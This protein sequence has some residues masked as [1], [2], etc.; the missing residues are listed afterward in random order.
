MAGV[1]VG[2][3]GGTN[4]RF[5][6]ADWA[7][8]RLVLSR[9]EL[10]AGEAFATFEDAVGH[11]LDATGLKPAGACIAVAGPVRDGAAHLTNR[12]WR[13]SEAVLRDRFGIAAPLVINDFLAMA[14]SVPEM[15]PESFE[16]VYD[17]EAVA[18]APLIVAG[19]GTGFGVSTL[20]PSPKG[21]TVL[22]GEGGHIAYA[23]RTALERELAAVLARDHGYVSNELVAS[24]SGLDEVHA[25]LSEIRGVPC[26]K[27]TAAEMQAKAD[28][29]DGFFAEL[30]Q[31]RALA[32]MGAVGD[33]A[34]AN[35]ALGGVVLAGGVSE[36]L[37]AY[38]RLPAMRERFV[39]RGPMSDYLARC[40]VRL[41][42]NPEAPLIGAA[43]H[44][45]QVHGV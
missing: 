42:R 14:R 24:G 13:V 43:A 37:A 11:Y 21:W 29:G 33:L 40:P 25:A 41:L 28:A 9:V 27:M 45:A 38:F 23:P 5:A 4:A 36:R 32:V 20:V 12:D 34:L 19:P 8:G 18:G 7:E 3:V 31:V 30:A 44:Y 15:G 39:A 35:G 16:E 26:A 1:L 6:L 22:A 17:G 10:H 2:D